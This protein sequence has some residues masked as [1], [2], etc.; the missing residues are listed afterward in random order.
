MDQTGLPSAWR[1]ASPPHNFHEVAEAVKLLI[2]NPDATVDEIM[3]V[4]PGPDFPTGGIICGR[5]GI[6]QGY[7]TGRSTLTLRAKTHFEVEKKSDVIVVSEIPYLDTRDRIREKLETLVRDD[8]IKG[9]SR[10]VDLTDRTLKSWQVR[11]HIVLKR[12]ADKEVVLNQ[13]FKFSPLQATVSV[14]LLAL[15]GNRPR[16]MTI[17]EMLVE[18]LRHRIE[19][20][21][22]RTEFLL[23]EARKRKHTVEGLLI[24]QI[25]ID[26]VIKTIR[27][28]SSRIEA[29]VNLQKIQID[30]GLIERALGDRGFKEFQAE[31][32]VSTT[33]SLSV[34]QSEA[35]VSMQLG[36]LANLEREKLSGEHSNLIDSIEEYLDLL[37][38]EDNIRALIQEE[39]D[40]LQ[41]KFSD[42]RRTEISEEELTNVDRAEL[43]RE[44]PMV[45][46]LSTRGYVKRTQ[47][48]TYKA[49]NRGGKGIKGAKSDDEDSIQH[50]FVTST[51]D[52]LL[53]F[54]NFGKVYWQKVYDLPLQ[55]RTAKGRALVNLLKLAEGE[56]VANC[57]AVR[58]FDD[59]RGLIMATK[60]GIVKKTALSAF[61]TPHERR[62]HWD[63]P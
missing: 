7:A 44:E 23:A 16:T 58:E 55:N 60:K 2:N 32:G 21:R 43:I 51:H 27:N 54:T 11:I 34:N 41:K 12:D 52:W 15:S 13:L 9:I 37:S 63:S 22:R 56:T 59:E 36:S 1:P 42:K 33:Y 49:Q 40:D 5:Y 30:A 25:D 50:L 17:K 18:F 38:D 8:R 4:L 24:A 14:I 62:H 26:E 39:L 6:R 47:L 35:I 19:V 48:T 3:D 28:S 20:L 57:V 61:K 45:V 10:I 53:F 46:T 31:Q 29:K